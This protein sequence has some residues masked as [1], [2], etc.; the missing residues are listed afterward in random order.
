MTS[1]RSGLAAFFEPN[2]VA[3]VGASGNPE[4]IMARP[5]EVLVSQ[6]F[7]GDVYAVN[8]RYDEIRGTPCFPRLSS[9]PAKVDLVVIAVP[10][11]EAAAVI[12]DCPAVGA[13]AAILLSAGFAEDGE[14]G[15]LR[16]E[17]LLTA[18]RAANVR[19]I[20]PNCQGVMYIP[21]RLF[22]TFTPAAEGPIAD[23][24]FAFVGQSGALGGYLLAAARASGLGMT[25]WATVGNQADCTCSEVATALLRREEVK[26]LALYLES[27]VD[28]A[29]LIEMAR[30]ANELDKSVVL[31]TGGQSPAGWRAALSHTGALVRPDAAFAVT[32]E[33]LGV[34]LVDD[35]DELH[36]ASYALLN[37]P[38]GAGSR[39]GGLS[40]SGGA[41]SLMADHIEGAGLTV[42]DTSSDLKAELA[43]YIPS[44]G[45]VENP[46][47]VTPQL[48]T[49]TASEFVSVMR[50]MALALEFDQIIIV[51]TQLGGAR[52]VIF[53]EAVVAIRAESEK[54]LHVC[55]LADAEF[56]KEGRG[57]LRE[58]SIPVY[59]SIRSAVTA[60]RRLAADRP[61]LLP[62]WQDR[63]DPR[64]ADLP[65]TVSHAQAAD[66]LTAVGVPQPSGRVVKHPQDAPDAVRAV[67]GRAV[68]KLQSPAAL[69]K[70]EAG[71][72]RL[73]VTA[74]SAT[75]V[76]TELLAGADPVT[77]GGVLVQEQIPPG[78]ELLI[79]VSRR[80]PGLPPVLT[81]GMGGVTAEVWEDVVSR[82]LP[83][84][85]S[86]VA[87]MLGTLK[88]SK[89]LRG[90]RG[91]PGYDLDAAAD[92]VM[93]LA[94]AAELVGERLIELEVNPLI[95][96]ERGA[97]CHA[98]DAL[99]RLV[100]KSE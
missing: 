3:V 95:I 9:I 65:E 24:G 48:F 89:L 23:T 79:G 16:Q 84:T 47:D 52:G 55:W 62:A 22:A 54:P 75:R 13:S 94:D 57:I 2:S 76:A 69:H 30:T 72:V 8:P 56:S 19:V 91:Q 68:L 98:A 61:S 50:I 66:L 73:G 46:V 77:T 14:T 12:A 25:A 63:L 40:S 31:L 78:F 96:H 82:P 29:G 1:T 28:P 4:S 58:G 70:T 37:S 74:E 53:A 60:A 85:H 81:I 88:C 59:G 87:T 20:G 27:V 15:R 18:A 32:A 49:G 67:G 11:D 86:E 5:L 93:K 10:A 21:R 43:V 45:S 51:V 7:E 97:G 92:A 71:L 44:F 34:V 6:G 90:F 83:L 100:A 64:F 80:N 36:D 39:I 38:R 99:L 26:V 35:L 42:A 17:E 33:R 41:G